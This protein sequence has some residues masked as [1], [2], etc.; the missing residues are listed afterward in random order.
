MATY[1]RM[2]QDAYF[3]NTTLLTETPGLRD[4]LEKEY[5]EIKKNQTVEQLYEQIA[6]R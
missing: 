4:Q 3:M 5:R 2:A 6:L 1:M